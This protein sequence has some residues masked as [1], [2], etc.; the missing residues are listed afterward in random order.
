M[1]DPVTLTIRAS[2]GVGLGLRAGYKASRGAGIAALTA[3]QGVAGL[4]KALWK[5]PTWAKGLALTTGALSATVAARAF[6][7]SSYAAEDHAESD[8]TGSYEPVS[9]VR[10]RMNRIGGGGDLVFGLH[11]RRH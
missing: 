3:S 11:A 9:G 6:T 7:E 2:E 8:G 4:G 10:E 1:I 5:S